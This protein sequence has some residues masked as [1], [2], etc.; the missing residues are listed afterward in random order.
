MP[1]DSHEKHGNPPNI[2]SLP[3]KEARNLVGEPDLH[4]LLLADIHPNGRRQLSLGHL[5]VPPTHTSITKAG[6][7]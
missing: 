5:A 3:L 1:R 2:G 7:P 4:Q 6:P